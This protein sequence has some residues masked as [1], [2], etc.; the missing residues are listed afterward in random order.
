MQFFR[1]LIFTTYLFVSTAVF[2]VA[3]LLSA[4]FPYGVRHAVAASWAR[5][6]LWVLK[7]CCRL[8][9]RVE[10]REN[11]PPGNHISMWKHS[12]SWET[13]AQMIIF[14]PQAWVLKHELTWIPILGWA[15]H[16][17]R[18]IAIDRGSGHVAVNQVLDQG[19]Q[20][21]E[22]GMWILVFPEGTRTAIGT[23][24]KYGI[25]GAL[26][27][28]QTGKLVVPVA[29]NAGLYWPRR[30]LLKK[31]GLIRVVIGAPI[32]PRGLEAR[33]LNERI[34]AWIESTVATLVPG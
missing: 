4:V 10:G 5:S 17:M 16:V 7:T 34:Q 11:I 12:S 22:A 25:S 33:E 15:I 19:K 32:D 6:G 18:P 21:L 28:T 26:L 9:Y 23:T 24:R 1:S 29:H 3:V 31:P 14:P 2:A 30:G 13:L 8:D 20:R 27:A